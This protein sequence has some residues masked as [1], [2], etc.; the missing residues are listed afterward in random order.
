MPILV[1]TDIMCRVGPL[2]HG[3]CPTAA[4]N[5]GALPRIGAPDT[6]GM[7]KV[8]IPA[9]ALLPGNNYSGGEE[10]SQPVVPQEACEQKNVYNLLRDAA[11]SPPQQAVDFEQLLAVSASRDP[12]TP[13]DGSL[14]TATKFVLLAREC[15]RQLQRHSHH[16]MDLCEVVAVLNVRITQVSQVA[17]DI[18]KDGDPAAGAK[19]VAAFVEDREEADIDSVRQTFAEQIMFST[20][21]LAVA[22]GSTT[23]EAPTLPPFS[24]PV[25]QKLLLNEFYDV[26]CDS[27]ANLCFDYAHVSPVIRMHLLFY[28]NFMLTLPSCQPHRVMGVVVSLLPF[29]ACSVVDPVF[30]RIAFTSLSRVLL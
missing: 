29:S 30:F 18:G 17:A 4:P 21:V 27:L 2:I 6:E 24:E 16:S 3:L 22:T 28:R 14:G 12:N 1:V 10:H 25:F 5:G 9:L 13:H 23:G 11:M 8:D 7:C 19:L 26:G 15:V 20:R